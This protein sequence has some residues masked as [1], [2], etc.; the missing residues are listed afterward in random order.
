MAG[1]VA[2][3]AVEFAKDRET[4]EPF[5]ESAGLDGK[6]GDLMEKSQL[7]GRGMNQSMFFSPPLS[8]TKD[9]IDFVVGQTEKVVTQL[10]KDLT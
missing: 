8:I 3:A 4:F 6:L 7:L 1:L 5:P 10:E 2:R 9:E